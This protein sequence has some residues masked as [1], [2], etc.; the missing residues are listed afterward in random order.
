M[1]LSNI[2]NCYLHYFLIKS[3]LLVFLTWRRHTIYWWKELFWKKPELLLYFGRETATPT[4]NHDPHHHHRVYTLLCIV[5]FFVFSS[6]IHMI[7]IIWDM[8]DFYRYLIV[9]NFAFDSFTFH[10]SINACVQTM[11]NQ[12]N[13]CIILCRIINRS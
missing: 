3:L 6:I 8:N 9:P 13:I 7:I 10:T 5:F 2:R 12:P 11:I 1:H 4:S